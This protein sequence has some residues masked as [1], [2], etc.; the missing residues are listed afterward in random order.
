MS[1]FALVSATP[2]H[3]LVTS[4]YPVLPRPG[5]K[6][7]K[8]TIAS[9]RASGPPRARLS[10]AAADALDPLIELAVFRIAIPRRGRVGLFK[11]TLRG[12]RRAAGDTGVRRQRGRH[13]WI[14]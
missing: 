10:T 14:G 6:L 11:L 12:Q 8:T 3:C 2:R 7:A 1:G 5:P 9:G 4:C 13:R